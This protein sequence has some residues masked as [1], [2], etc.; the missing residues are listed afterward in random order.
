MPATS[1][2]DSA[3]VGQ[4][5]KIGKYDVLRLIGRGGMGVVYE[6]LDPKLERHV[7]IKMILGATPGLLTRF[8]REARSTASLQHPNIVTIYEFGDQEGSPYLVMEY[9]S[10]MSLESA[11][12]SGQALSLANKL[13][14]CIDVCNGLSYAHDRGII[15]RDIKPANVMLLEDGTV[16]IVDFGIARMGDTGISRTEIIGSLHYMSPEQFQNQTLDRRT[17]IFSTGVVL[18]QLLTGALP[19]QATGGEAAVMYRIMHEDP[20]PLSFYR[21]DY[22]PE[23]DEI[24]RRVLAKNRDLRYP[25]ARDLSFDLQAV[26]EKEKHQEV[27]QWMT[28]ADLAVQKTEWTKAEDYLRQVLRVDHHHVPAHQLLGQVQGRIRQQRNVEQVRELRTQADQAFLNRRYD[29]AL[30]ILDQAIA[31]DQTDQDLLGLRKSINEAKS[32]VARFDLALRR[33]EEAQRAGDL[34][35]AKL[36]IREALEIDPSET[37]AK[38]LQV[39]ILKQA[40]EQERQQRL[41]TLFDSA[42]DQITARDLTSALQTL[43]EAELLDSASVEL[44]SL[45]KVVNAAREEQFRKSELTKL[46]R[47]IEEALNR[48]DYTAATAVA[49]EGLQRYPREQILLKLRALAEAQQQ[50]VQLKAYARDQLLAATGLL[51]AGRAVQALSVIESARRVIPSDTQLESLQK[52]VEDRIALE[53][54]EERKLQL[55]QCARELAAAEKFDDAVR[56]LETLRRDFPGSEEIETLLENAG[57]AAKHA[58]LVTQALGLGQQLLDQG[59]PEQAVQFLEHKTLELSDA[60]LFDL[61]E[62]ARRQRVQFQSDLQSSI[63][64]GKR[65]LQQRGA[66]EAA[67]YL[68]ARPTNF[69]E[70]P[71]LRA[72][73]EAVASR[74]AYDALDQELEH[75]NDPDAQVRLAEAALRENPRNEDIRKKLS[76]ARSR[77]QQINEI[78]VKARALETSQQYLEAAEEWR[79]LRRVYPQYAGLESEIGRLERLEEQRLLED[80]RRQQEMY[81]LQAKQE[82]EKRRQAL[83]ATLCE[84][85]RIL[86]ERGAQDAMQYLDSQAAEYGGSQQFRELHESVRDREGLDAL[87]SKLANESNLERQLQSAEAALRHRRSNRLIQQKVADLRKLKDRIDGHVKQAQG[88]ESAGLLAEA[89]QKWQQLAVSYPNISEFDAQ[90][91]RLASLLESREKATRT[92]AAPPNSEQSSATEILDLA[93]VRDVEPSDHAVRKREIAPVPEPVEKLAEI[94]EERPSKKGGRVSLA[95]WARAAVGVLAIAIVVLVL[96]RHR[97]QAQTPLPG[98]VELNPIPWAEIVAVKNVRGG[99]QSVVNFSGKTPLRMSLPPGDYLIQLRGPIG[100]QEMSVRVEPG[101]LARRT[102]T[103]SGFDADKVV[104]ELLKQN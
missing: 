88:S 98:Y 72:L 75:E 60:R 83:E 31:I 33:A 13:S 79:R 47:E 46:A 92:I 43:K 34:E 1:A 76:A 84:G 11:I 69:R 10:G 26:A 63:E 30:R 9:L 21:Q 78:A 103:L 74:S 51:E 14:I 86:R 80:A 50:R 22:P 68:A 100:T 67:Q 56:L 5:T 102:D 81:E 61:L 35:E 38:A 53:E 17:D 18:Y 45:R 2:E 7:A 93:A 82:A 28:R 91:R 37:S 71:E 23:L 66:S 6:A 24:I 39:V 3:L 48:E 70:R 57:A 16:K 87:N 58:E 41:R 90:V 104:D 15:H 99:S 97:P 101:K 20:A 62:H 29:E 36:A 96:V 42:R 32:R 19:F 64:E 4:P 65:I 89:M 40:E 54:A 77:K 95:V 8:D 12:S 49:D 94:S 59:S 73:A 52:I 85:E 44:Y 25:S 27:L 55:L